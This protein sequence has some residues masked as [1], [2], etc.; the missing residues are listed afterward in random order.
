M[1]RIHARILAVSVLLAAASPATFAA[2]GTITFTGRVTGQTC[3]IAGNGAA[4]D[5][6]V[7]L[8]TVGA[9]TLNAAGNTAGRTAFNITLSGCTPATGNVAVYFEAGTNTD[10]TTGRLRNAAVA[11][12]AVGDTPAVT[13]A[14]NVQIGV[15]NA[16]FSPISIG[17][18]AA[19]Q[20]SQSVALAAGAA[21][22]QYYAQYVATG[23]AST[24]GEVTT[25]AQY[26]IQYP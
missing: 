14:G 12:P 7:A 26:S 1:K 17:S 23:G 21:T 18:A 2:D 10:L 11:A 8:P 9:S 6:T 19:S 16:D 13:P 25:T 22:L 5:F 20:N 4:S 15:L 24:A 3:T